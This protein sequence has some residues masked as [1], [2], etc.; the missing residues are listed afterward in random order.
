MEEG[1]NAASRRLVFP[2]DGGVIR[3]VGLNNE[4]C[5][6]ILLQ[7]LMPPSMTG[8]VCVSTYYGSVR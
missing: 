5:V 3:D 4:Q 6:I 1:T 7:R 8:C 2:L